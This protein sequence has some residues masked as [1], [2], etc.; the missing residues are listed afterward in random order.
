MD[1]IF[2]KWT[3]F[4]NNGDFEYNHWLS[5]LTL[6]LLGQTVFHHDFGLLDGKLSEHYEAYRTIF[7]SN[8]SVYTLLYGF[9]PF[10]ENFPFIG[11][12]KIQSSVDILYSLF[13]DMISEHKLKPQGDI[14]DHLLQ[15][16]ESHKLSTKELYSNIWVLFLAGHETTAKAL[17]WAI[18]ELA[19]KPHIQEKLY[20]IIQTTWGNEIPSYESIAK[21]PE[22]LQAFINENLRKHPPAPAL[23]TRTALKDIQYGDQIIPAGVHLGIDMTSIHHDPEHWEN[24]DVFDPD[25]FL[26]EN[27]KGRHRFAFLPFSLG[28][29]QCIGNEFSEIEQRLFLVRML[30][31]WKILTPKNHPPA[32]YSQRRWF[33]PQTNPFYIQIEKR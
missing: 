25:R 22:Y 31:R 3:Q 8:L 10:L 12:K 13:S 18:A 26:P 21:P 14:L 15:G 9:F 1:K 29:R 6:D 30:Q 17:L 27:K 2:T 24:P 7:Y 11:A 5:K 23:P 16:S 4:E 19:D 33:I 28:A 20:Q 32:N